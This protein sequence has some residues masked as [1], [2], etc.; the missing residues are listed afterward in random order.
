MLFVITLVSGGTVYQV[1][2][3]DSPRGV[4][5]SA[6]HAET[7]R[8]QSIFVFYIGFQCKS[9]EGHFRE[10]FFVCMF[11]VKCIHVKLRDIALVATKVVHV[12]L[13][14]FEVLT[15]GC[16]IKED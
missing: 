10:P 16:M 7:R 2:S 12:I 6:L 14:S 3:M 11:L 9:S 1:H 5:S 4:R 15:Q 8:I 13:R